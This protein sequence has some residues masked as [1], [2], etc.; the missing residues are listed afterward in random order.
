MRR[1]RGGTAGAAGGTGRSRSASESMRRLG[2]P[3]AR[4]P[5]LFAQMP[6]SRLTAR[7]TATLSAVGLA[8]VADA[9]FNDNSLNFNSS[10][11][12]RWPRGSPRASGVR[13]RAS[14]ASS[15]SFVATAAKFHAPRQFDLAR[16]SPARDGAT[17]RPAGCAPRRP[18]RVQ[19]AASVGM[20]DGVDGEQH[21]LDAV[22][23]VVGR[24]SGTTG[25]ATDIGSDGFDRAGRPCRRRPAPTP[26]CATSLRGRRR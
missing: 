4:L 13:R 14:S 2:V 26:S 16:P 25:Q 12:S 3:M 7:W 6:R 23:A 24:Q 15:M 19:T 11:A 10:T 8:T 18:A 17:G 20:A 22:L 21:V 5:F 9:S 1:A